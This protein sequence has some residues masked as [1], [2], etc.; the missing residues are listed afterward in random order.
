MSLPD[1]AP[2]PVRFAKIARFVRCQ[3][4]V[5]ACLLSA[6]ILLTAS[7]MV[8]NVVSRTLTGFSL[9]FTEEV[10]QFLIIGVTFVGLSYAAGRGRHIRMTAVVDQLSE[11]WRK[12]VRIFN[13]ILTSGLLLALAGFSMQ[14]IT[15]VHFLGTVSPVLQVPL[16]LVYLI[17][18]LGLTL[19][20][21]QYGLTAF[22]NFT[23]EG[24][25]LSFDVKDEYV[26]QEP[27]HAACPPQD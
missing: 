15:T 27:G 20:A 12:R 2:P 1:S 5:E 3:Q 18:P 6:M 26:S 8:T 14:Y 19:A 16:Y 4:R 22:R 11:R 21:M 17:V 23:S 25:W 10:S 24:V 13:A 9:A 7:L